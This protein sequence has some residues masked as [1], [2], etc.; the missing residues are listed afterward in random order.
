MKR[1]KKFLKEDI[2]LSAKNKK[3]EEKENLEKKYKKKSQI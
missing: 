3:I 1:K 2:S